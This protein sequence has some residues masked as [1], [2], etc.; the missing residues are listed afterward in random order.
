MTDRPLS[1]S[2]ARVPA[3]QEEMEKALNEL[4]MG[5]VRLDECSDAAE[6]QGRPL[7]DRISAKIQKLSDARSE[8]E[9]TLKA[10]VAE[11]DILRARAEAA[12]HRRLAAEYRAQRIVLDGEL[13]Q[14]AETAEAQLAALQAAAIH[15]QAKPKEPDVVPLDDPSVPYSLVPVPD[16]PTAA[17]PSQ[18]ETPE[19]G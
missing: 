4:R 11:M 9:H 18:A 12:E 1:A 2:S 3:S 14:R 6:T 17:A 8:I 16:P 19:A 5:H 10:I 13:K 7:Y 15:L